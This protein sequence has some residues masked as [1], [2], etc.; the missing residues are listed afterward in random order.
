[1]LGK[2]DRFWDTSAV[3]HGSAD[4]LGNSYSFILDKVAFLN[5]G[6]CQRI[7]R[8]Q[9][10][11]SGAGSTVTKSIECAI[12]GRARYPVRAISLLAGALIRSG[13]VAGT[14][15]TAFQ[16]LNRPYAGW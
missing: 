6:N 10:G 4:T 13:L 3:E 1:M 16:P 11:R 14:R 2:L 7:V 15:T 9:R 5:I 12:C 8:R